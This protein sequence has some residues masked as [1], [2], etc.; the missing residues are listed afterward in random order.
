MLLLCRRGI[1][2]GKKKLVATISRNRICMQPMRQ[3]EG[4]S[5]FPFGQGEDGIFFII[6][7]PW[8]SPWCYQ[9]LNGF[10]PIMFPKGVPNSTSLYLISFA[11]SFPLVSYIGEPKG[12]HLM[13][14]RSSLLGRSHASFPGWWADQNGPLEEKKKTWA[15]NPFNE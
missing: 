14:L 10:V 11:Q 7:F 8:C 4:S 6:L 13:A 3:Q 9:V 12:K 2:W 1:S 5:F 15:T